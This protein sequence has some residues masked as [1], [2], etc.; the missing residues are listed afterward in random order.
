MS[1]PFVEL[2]CHSNFSFLDGASPVEDLVE[3]A[4]AVGLT[5]LAV[6]DHQGLYGAVRFAT[7]AQQAGLRPIVGIEIEL[8]D[9]AV[10][11]PA[12]IVVPPPRRRR[13]ASGRAA[14]ADGPGLSAVPPADGRALRPPTERLRPPG[15]RPARREDLRGVRSRELGPHIVLLARDMTGYRSLCRLTSAAHLAGTKGVPR[16]SHALLAQHTDGLAA[17]SGCRQGEIGRRLL[18]GDREGATAAAERLAALFG[19][20]FHVELQHHLL[21]DDDWLVSQSVG[22]AR[23][24]SLPMVVT[25]DAHYATPDGRELQDVLVCIRHGATLETS[26]HLRR[27]NGEYY[28]KGAAELAA[29]PPARG[30]LGAGIAAA[31]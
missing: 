14:A 13:R 3:R 4:L 1:G 5:S 9:A 2:H 28:L 29:L 7:A 18:A 25:N 31:W 11:D 17:L 21:P 6:T 23:A 19:T 15:H 20:D 30:D 27:P 12:G 16:F 22:L 10:A 24:L 8:T 26:G